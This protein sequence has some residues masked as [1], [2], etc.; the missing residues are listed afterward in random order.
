MNPNLVGH[1]LVTRYTPAD[2]YWLAQRRVLGRIA[3][4]D[5]PG[6][7]FWQ[8]VRSVCRDALVNVG[9]TRNWS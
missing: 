3:E 6:L 2:A 5:S 7:R 4:G 1:R 8:A 9:V